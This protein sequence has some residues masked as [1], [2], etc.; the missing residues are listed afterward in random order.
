MEAAAVAKAQPPKE[1]MT[2]TMPEP[3]AV[4]YPQFSVRLTSTCAIMAWF[5]ADIQSFFR[6]SYNF[7]HLRCFLPFLILYMCFIKIIKAFFVFFS[8]VTGQRDSAVIAEQQLQSL[9]MA[10]AMPMPHDMKA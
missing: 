6:I 3:F 9:F 5:S 8:F 10:V 4:N 2:P 1:P 7:L